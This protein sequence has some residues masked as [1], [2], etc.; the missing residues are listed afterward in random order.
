MYLGIYGAILILNRQFGGIFSDCCNIIVSVIIIVCG[1]KNGLKNDLII[2]ACLIA[3]SFLLG[4]I[5]TWIYTF[6]GAAAG[7]LICRSIEKG[8]L[9]TRLLFSSIAAYSA[10]ELAVNFL[11]YP[12]LGM[13]VSSRI[14]AMTGLFEIFSIPHG[15]ELAIMF[16]ILTILVIAVAESVAIIY[17]AGIL[18]KRIRI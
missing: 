18:L 4:D 15:F 8:V 1:L 16:F 10:S 7:M 14:R 2:A 17:L 12:L 11:I 6:I 13:R 3:F 9:G 5:K